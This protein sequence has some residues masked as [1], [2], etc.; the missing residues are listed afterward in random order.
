MASAAVRK[1]L[2]HERRMTGLHFWAT[3]VLRQHGRLN[4]KRV[5]QYIREQEKLE[6]GQ[7][8]LDPK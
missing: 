8:D 5:R 1:L 3:G 4:E 2:L 6:R 7:G